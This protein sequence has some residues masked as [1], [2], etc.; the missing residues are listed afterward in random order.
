MRGLEQLLAGHP[1]A[2]AIDEM[3]AYWRAKRVGDALPRRDAIDPSEI[4]ALLPHIVIAEVLDGG[5]RFRYRLAGTHVVQ[6]FGFELTGRHMDEVLEGEPLAFLVG[7]YERV[8]AE[9]RP[10]FTE[11]RYRAANGTDL[12]ITRLILPLAESG[13]A[14]RQIMTLLLTR[15]GTTSAAVVALAEPGDNRSHRMEPLD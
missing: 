10:L 13:G 7:A 4:K 14:V 12:L 15:F 2:A 11:S 6:A 3:Y 8:C 9:G 5:R 1:H